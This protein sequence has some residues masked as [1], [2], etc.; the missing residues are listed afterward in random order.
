LK[1]RY[2]NLEKTQKNREWG[3]IHFPSN[4]QLISEIAGK[5]REEHVVE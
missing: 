3:K 1:P 4:L 2:E 5:P